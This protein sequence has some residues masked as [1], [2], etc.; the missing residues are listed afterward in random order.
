MS[1]W[2]EFVHRRD[3]RSPARCASAANRF[4]AGQRYHP[5]SRIFVIAVTGGHTV[6]NHAS[7]VRGELAREQRGGPPRRARGD[8]SEGGQGGGTG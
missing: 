7:I 6:T 5:E 1:E 2:R 4:I 3:F 8:R